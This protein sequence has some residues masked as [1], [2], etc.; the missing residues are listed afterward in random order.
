MLTIFL[1]SHIYSFG[2]VCIPLNKIRITN[3]GVDKMCIVEF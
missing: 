1:F 3:L 2:I